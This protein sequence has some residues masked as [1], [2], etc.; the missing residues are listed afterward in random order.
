MSKP[1]LFSVLL[2]VIVFPVVSTCFDHPDALTFGKWFLFFA[3]G[4][5]LFIA[6]L[7]Q[8]LNPAFTARD[9]FHLKEEASYAVVR[10]LGF[11][12]ICFGVVGILSLFFPTWRI[13]SVTGS[14]LYFGLAGLLHLVKWPAGPNERLALVSDL[15]IFAC[16]GIYAWLLLG[17]A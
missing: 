15:F 14:G 4:L 17:K 7:R 9:I 3:V 8:A 12:N 13:V 16:L 5:R 1:Y 2:L 11:A 6:G 10:E